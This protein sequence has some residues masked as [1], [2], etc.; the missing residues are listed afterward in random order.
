MREFPI[1]KRD[2]LVAYEA[3]VYSVDIRDER[4]DLSIGR[5]NE[6]FD[7]LLKQKSVKEWSY[8]TAYNPFSKP[9]TE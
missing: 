4:F 3:T 5:I 6:E 1:E 9:L 8:I 2:L 7:R